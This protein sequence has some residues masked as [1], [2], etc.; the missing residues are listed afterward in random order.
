MRKAVFVFLLLSVTFLTVTVPGA[1][2]EQADSV[3]VPILNLSAPRLMAT[4][5][6]LRREYR[7]R[8]AVELFRQAR[9]KTTDSLRLMRID[10]QM[11]MAQN[12]DNMREYCSQ[13]VVIARQRFSLED[14]FLFYP[15]LDGAWRPVPNQLDSLGTDG[16]ARGMYIPQEA[17]VLYYSAKDED[18]MYNLYRTEVLDTVWSVPEL[19][20]EQMTS[21]DNEIFP[22]LSPD[23]KSL[24]FASNGLYGMGGYDLYVS[25]W[26]PE[27]R[28]WDVPMNMGFP[29][30]S[31][32]DDYLFVNTPDG[33]YS[34]FASNRE[35]S[36][37]SV[38]IYVLEYDSMPVRKAVEDPAALRALA[39]LHPVADPGRMDNGSAAS[40]AVQENV[41]IR[42]YTEKMIRVRILRDSVSL[43]NKS[44]DE[45]RSALSSA[46]E[47]AKA[48]L[49]AEIRSKEE[50]LPRLQEALTEATKQLQE[51]EMEFLLGGVVIDP[52]TVRK[53]ADRE[54]VGASSGYTFT[55]RSMGPA[56][57]MKILKP[58][59]S[60]DYSFKILPEGRFAE[61]NTLPDGL[62]YQIQL[63]SM[64]TKATV[65]QLKGLSPVFERTSS[66]KYIYSAGLFNTYKDV[67]SNLNKV[68]RA[69]FKSAFITAYL[70]GQP[71]A[72]SK[73][74][75]L[76]KTVRQLYQIRLWPSDGKALSDG[77]LTSIHSV[78]DAD[79]S[80]M[81]FEGAMTYVLGPFDDKAEVDGIVA[82]LKT[83]G[84]EKLSVEKAGTAVR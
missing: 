55:R 12:G 49:A 56:P 13:P 37:D 40:N 67:L 62:V 21:S 79:L 81:V 43:F 25:Q 5:D 2:R 78:T 18:G 16:P 7:F 44:I 8:E 48:S 41:D 68:K 10:E 17:D 9:A 71:I 72:V 22:M 1:A 76:E 65:R 47:E 66:Q 61:N 59:P 14:F 70:D 3:V 23:G 52:E 31:P 69:G 50:Q 32:Y 28:D 27:T 36:R 57:K 83:A 20:G 45:A 73:A 15:L 6:S 38:Y 30:S 4:A 53:E 77:G 63:F 34:M 33:K 64:S 60:F 84:L 74:R 39:S 82:A 54:I 51:I 35:C 80:K 11:A 75:E 58:K 19:L 29:Y 46:S 24:F 42:R 26:N